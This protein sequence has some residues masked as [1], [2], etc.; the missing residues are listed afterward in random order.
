MISLS[1]RTLL[2]LA[3]LV[4]FAARAQTAAPPKRLLVVF[5]P[6]G[7]LEP[8]FWPTLPSSR[9]PSVYSTDS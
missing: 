1:R 5:S 7:Y 9:K 4:P 2:K 6:M 3:P 8:S